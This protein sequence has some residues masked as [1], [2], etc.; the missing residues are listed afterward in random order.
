MSPHHRI[1]SCVATLAALAPV[2][3]A[4][5]Q[6][7]YEAALARCEELEKRLSLNYHVQGWE[8]LAK[9]LDARAIEALAR[10]YHDPERPH[11]QV[12]Y[13]LAGAAAL[14]GGSADTVA[15]FDAW[16]EEER[17]SKDAWLWFHALTVRGRHVG[18][19]DL[20]LV[21]RADENPFLRAAAIEALAR[22]HRPQAIEAIPEMCAALPEEPGEQSALVGALAT[23]L[24]KTADRKTRTESA[25]QQAALSMVALLEREE[26]P[27]GA[28]LVIARHLA[29]ALDADQVVLEAAAWRALIAGRAAE[30]KKQGPEYVKPRFFGIEA[31]GER[32]C[33]VVDLSDSMCAPIPP[34]LAERHTGGPVTGGGEKEPKK[35]KGPKELPSE[36]DIPWH[37]V[38]TRFDLAREHL[39]IS[40]QCLTEDQSFCVVVFGDRAELLDGLTGMVPAKSSTVKKAIAALDDIEIGSPRNDR[41]DGVL[42]GKTNLH[43]GMRTA[44]RLTRKGLV[45]EH[46]YVDPDTFLEGCDTIFLLSDGDP[47]W[48]DYDIKDQDYK[49]VPV[50]DPETDE[51]SER[52]AELHYQGPYANWPKLLEDVERMNLFREVEIHGIV[53]GE[54]DGGWMK[55]LVELGLGSVTKYDS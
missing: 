44:F 16:R 46:E 30:A 5:A 42:L 19:T 15:A 45:E 28:K 36:E 22:D 2:P 50:G 14:N 54:V 10:R 41:P 17:T 18:P 32:I 52:A 33:Y 55:K 35:K 3:T 40:L 37:R 39:R 26:L 25:W 20:A 47:T 9:S 49:D 12:Q 53:I 24:L 48:D 43:A 31:N 34:T 23:A 4:A 8:T 27:R 13:L 1:L 7:G 6:S 38:K 11:E 51:P 29:R 21:A